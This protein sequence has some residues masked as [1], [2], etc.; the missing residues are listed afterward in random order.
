MGIA[1]SGN[2]LYILHDSDAEW[3]FYYASIG[4]LSLSVPFPYVFFNIGG[5]ISMFVASH[6]QYYPRG[7]DA[8]KVGTNTIWNEQRT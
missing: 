3:R 4:S 2:K 5:A 8:R 6:T 7:N 1:P